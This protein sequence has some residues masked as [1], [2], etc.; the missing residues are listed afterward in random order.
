MDILT[1]NV[2]VFRTAAPKHMIPKV[3]TISPELQ[4]ASGIDKNP[5][6][7]VDLIICMA[8]AKFLYGEWI[9]GNKTQRFKEAYLIILKLYLSVSNSYSTK[10][11]RVGVYII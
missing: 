4:K 2:I 10:H 5:P 3:P 7:I 8:A 11:T 6:P 9:T 1:I